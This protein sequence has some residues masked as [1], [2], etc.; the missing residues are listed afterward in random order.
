[1]SCHLVVVVCACACVCACVCVCMCVC[2]NQYEWDVK[3]RRKN[4]GKKE[5]QNRDV[6][7]HKADDE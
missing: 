4:Y 6:L 3:K 5:Q 2:V 7:V 1:M